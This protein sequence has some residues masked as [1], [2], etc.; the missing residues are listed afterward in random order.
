MSTAGARLVFGCG[1]VGHRVA[2]AWLN[3]GNYVAVVTRSADRAKQFA[4]EGF[5]PVIADV[6]SPATL[7]E[8]PAAETVL[9]AVGYD[10]TR[11][12]SISEVYARGLQN[13]LNALPPE[14]GRLIYISSTGVY[15]DAGG[16][17]IDE[18]TPAV[19]SREGG[20]ACLAAEQVLPAHPLG[21]NG[22]VLRL[23]GIYGPGRVPR[24]EAVLAGKPISGKGD[25]FL[26]LI[27]VEDAV[28]SVLA[29]ERL[30][31]RRRTYN[32]SDGNPVRRADYYAEL[33]RLCG[34]PP[35]QFSGVIESERS[36][37]DANKRVS[38]A[39][40]LS[41]LAVNLQYPTYRDGL[42]AIVR[43]M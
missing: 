3:R 31:P 22:I 43:E 6:M 32:V 2:K 19:P 10:R 17:W 1:Y 39:R 40:M 4:A 29:A 15:G 5:H 7:C 28:A 12:W 25:G 14:T 34:A 30:A 37:G 26:N 42:A 21:A 36:G 8:L 20:K 24:R 38:N 13:V 16:E 11:P 27:H 33:A 23:A 35:P 41:E 9:F 18:D